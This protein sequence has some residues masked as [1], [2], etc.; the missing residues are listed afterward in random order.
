MLCQKTVVLICNITIYFILL[1]TFD[2]WMYSFEAFSERRSYIL[3]WVEG[4]CLYIY[5]SCCF[6][7]HVYILGT[8]GLIMCSLDRVS[9]WGT[10]LHLVT[11]R[12][13]SLSSTHQYTWL[14]WHLSECKVYSDIIYS[15]PQTTPK[16]LV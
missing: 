15:E 16:N 2:Q 9:H 3:M 8:S 7:L 13:P 4:R 1:I 12:G 14:L 10:D 5:L 6:F 11:R